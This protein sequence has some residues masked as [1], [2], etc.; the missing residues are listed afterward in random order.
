MNRSM[1]ALFVASAAALTLSTPCRAQFVVFDPTNFVE[2]ALTAARTLQEINNQVQQLQHEA[3]ML[4]NQARNLTTLPFDIVPRLRALL[5]NTQALINVAQGVGFRLNS[6]QATFARFYPVAYG[7]GQSGAAMA[8][9]AAQ[10]WLHSLQ[11]LQTAV[12]LQAQAAEN[13]PADEA[14]LADL[15]GQSQGAI[16]ALQAMQATNQLLAL[17]ARQSIQ[18]QQLRLAQDRSVALEQARSIAAEARAAEVRRRFQGS[19]VQYTPQPVDFYGF[20][21]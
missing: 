1:S 5:A 9:D 16:G 17:Q 8:A 4:I 6:A 15:V 7:P 2:N 19:G 13:L 21:P 12:S 18:G 3:Q 11:S 14:S 20:A 10:R